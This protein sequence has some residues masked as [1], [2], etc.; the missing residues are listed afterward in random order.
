MQATT[1]LTLTLPPL[2][3]G[4]ADQPLGLA[5]ATA[6]GLQVDDADT[7][8]HRVLLPDN[9][10]TFNGYYGS[11]PNG[12]HYKTFPLLTRTASSDPV[13]DWADLPLS[14]ATLRLIAIDVRPLYPLTDIRATGTLTSTNTNVTAGDTV[15]IDGKTY[16]YR[17][18]LTPAEGEVLR[19]ATADASLQ[20]LIYAINHTGTPGTHYSCAA[21]HPSVSAAPAVTAAHQVLISSLLPGLVY[22]LIIL[23]ETAATLSWSS[24]TLTGSQDPTARTL[25]GTVRIELKNSLLPSTATYPG[26]LDI[27]LASPSLLT[28]AVPA[29]WEPNAVAYLKVTFREPTDTNPKIVNAACTLLLIGTRA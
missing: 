29:G 27:T 21:A 5:A 9:V 2:T 25:E 10:D 16:T 15:S 8:L 14:L 28:F 11:I 7:V 24:A 3:P 17:A 4:A 23:A 6:L 12:Y 22:N 18:A 1:A 26:S 13:R 20:N 19:G